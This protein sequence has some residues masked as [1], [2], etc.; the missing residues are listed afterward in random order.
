[1]PELKQGTTNTQ[2]R[3]GRAWLPEVVLQRGPQV[4]VL[5][6]DARQPLGLLLAGEALFGALGQSNAPG[7]VSTLQ[8][9]DL[10]CLEELLARVLADGF[11]HP[12]PHT[13]PP[14]F[15]Q[16]Q[17]LVHETREHV[18]EVVG[19]RVR[20]GGRRSEIFVG[21]IAINPRFATGNRV[22]SA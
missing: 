22:P 14:I 3:L 4:I 11:E 10:P 12:V 6:V 7:P 9:F 1:M 8:R 16:D 19:C 5:R 21:S 18:E 2:R 13:R 20:G 17:R 15:D